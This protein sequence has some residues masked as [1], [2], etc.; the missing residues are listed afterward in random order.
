MSFH[1]AML[2]EKKEKNRVQ[3]NLCGRRCLINDGSTGFCLVRKNE[4]GILSTLVYGKAVSA[5]VD[6][7]GKKP[8]SH[9]NPGSLV[10]SIAAAGCN[11]RCKFCDNWMISQDQKI[12]G[13]TFS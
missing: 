5:A 7:I 3:C 9:F 4:T 6:P 13:K 8:L 2:Y 10:M 11:F 1:E 12:P